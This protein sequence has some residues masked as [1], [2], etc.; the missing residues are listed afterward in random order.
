VKKAQDAYT[1]KNGKP[2]ALIFLQNHGVFVGADD[3]PGIK[4]QYRR[5]MEKIG[6]KITRRPDLSGQI[7]D[8]GIS[9]KITAVL[10]ELADTAD[11]ARN[12]AKT[13]GPAAW[14]AAFRRDNAIAA[15]VKDPKSF[16]PVSSSFS[17]DHIVYAGSDP[18]FVETQSSSAEEVSAAV[19]KAWEKHLDKTR[20]IPKIAAVQ[21]LGVFGIGVSDKAVKTALELFTDAVKVAAYTEAFGGPQF[22]IP[23]Q[24]DFINN[25]ETEQYRSNIAFKGA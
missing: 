9:G 23:D 24:I 2:G 18:L 22:M 13:A 4:E 21:G 17:P 19:R 6:G 20:R 1:A 14:H 12:G 16:Y 10:T 3:I 8:W 5:I 25:W 11:R 7:A 15:L